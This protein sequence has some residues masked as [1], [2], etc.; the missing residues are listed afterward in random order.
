MTKQHILAIAV[1]ALGTSGSALA[2][3]ALAATTIPQPS[4]WMS[5]GCALL[6]LTTMQRRR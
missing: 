1:L 6:L 5:T 4:S 3:P 2:A